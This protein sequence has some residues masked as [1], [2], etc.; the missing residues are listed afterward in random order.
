[1]GEEEGST[2]SG[3]NL[4]QQKQTGGAGWQSDPKGSGGIG[5]ET[6]EGPAYSWLSPGLVFSDQVLRAES[7]VYLQG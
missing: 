2:W 5:V 6:L 3:W 7:V 4:Q 1:M